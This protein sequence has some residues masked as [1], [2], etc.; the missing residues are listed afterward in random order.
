MALLFFLYDFFRDNEVILL[1][2]MLLAF[3]YNL[4]EGGNNCPKQVIKHHSTRTLQ[5]SS[6]RFSHCQQNTKV[7]PGIAKTDYQFSSLAYPTRQHHEGCYSDC[8]AVPGTL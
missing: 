3:G 6:Y 5:S 1:E 4:N 8:L 7:L 2:K